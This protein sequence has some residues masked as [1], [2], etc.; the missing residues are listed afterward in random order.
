MVILSVSDT[1]DSELTPFQQKPKTI[2]LKFA[3]RPT[4]FCSVVCF[5]SSYE[6]K[7]RLVLFFQS[8]SFK[9]TVSVYLFFFASF[10]SYLIPFFKSSNVNGYALFVITTVATRG[11]GTAFPSGLHDLILIFTGV[12]S[13][14]FCVVFCRSLLFF[15]ALFY[16]FF[17]FRHYFKIRRQN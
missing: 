9:T 2:K 3:Y 1:I 6:I 12:R 5:S 7:I 8:V 10:R 13:L 4:P 14:L 17:D 16:L 11:A 15:V